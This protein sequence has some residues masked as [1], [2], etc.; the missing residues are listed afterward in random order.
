MTFGFFSRIL[1]V[2]RRILAAAAL[3]LLGCS[4]ESSFSCDPSVIVASEGDT[5]WRLAEEACEGEITLAVDEAYRIN[6][7]LSVGEAVVFPKKEGCRLV[8]VGKTEPRLEQNCR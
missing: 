8:W 3:C 1:L 2:V 6:G 4:S 5:I 7:E